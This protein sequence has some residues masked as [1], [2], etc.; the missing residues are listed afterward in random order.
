MHRILKFTTQI[1]FFN[2]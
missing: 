1:R 2:W